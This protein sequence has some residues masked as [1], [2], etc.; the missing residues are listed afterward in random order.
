MFTFHIASGL[1]PLT[2]TAPGTFHHVRVTFS[3]LKRQPWNQ[4]QAIKGVAEHFRPP[5]MASRCKGRQS[6]SKIK[7]G[8]W[9]SAQSS[10]YRDSNSRLC[11]N[12]C[13]AVTDA[14]AAFTGTEHF[15]GP[16]KKMIN[17]LLKSSTAV[18]ILHISCRNDWLFLIGAE[19]SVQ[20]TKNCSNKN[21]P[22]FCQT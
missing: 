9:G 19:C 15:S 22:S 2:S 20:S 5:A 4:Q 8:N 1:A 3:F 7:K 6:H 21:N 13:L 12:T 10:F 18:F 11:S 16:V 17:H 14:T